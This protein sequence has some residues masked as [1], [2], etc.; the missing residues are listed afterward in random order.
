M[1]K[2]PYIE[3]IDKE[4]LNTYAMIEPIE[5]WFEL[6]YYDVGEFE[7]KARA[8]INNLASLKKGQYVKIPNK[9]FV[10]VITS[11][12]YNFTKGGARIIT[13]TGYECKWLLSK[14]VIQTP[15]QLPLTLTNAINKLFNDN[16][17]TNA[18]ATRKINN[19][20][21]QLINIDINLTDTQAPRV[22]LLEFV[23]NLLKTYKCGSYVL[24]E[25]GKLYYTVIQGQDKHLSVKFSQSLDN[26]LSSEYLEDEEDLASNA[27]VVST[28]DDIDYTLEHDTGATGIDRAE[29]LINSNLSV[30]Y[31]DANGVEQE[32]TP[33]SDLYKGWQVEEGKKEL[34]NHINIVE[35]IGEIDLINSNYE[36]DNDFFIGD[37]V[38][39]K[40]EYFN[41]SLTPRILK[42]TISQDTKGKYTET[43]DYGE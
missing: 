31:T 1:N 23:N 4:E 2:I 5:C 28:I 8:T 30:K 22:N 25:N 41:F 19:F 11:V 17:G 13:A 37:I 16:I 18:L 3:L 38:G 32:T 12:K 20:E 33:T 43:A 6:S 14:R 9:R 40:D 42:Y 7:I 29:I 26:L 27:L 24:F 39:V 15:I 34:S 21:L 10:W 36:F 35:V